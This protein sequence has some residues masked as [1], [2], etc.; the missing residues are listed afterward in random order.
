LIRGALPLRSLP[1]RSRYGEGGYLL[2]R[3]GAYH[4]V[5]T[6]SRSVE[7]PVLCTVSNC[8]ALQH[9]VFQKLPTITL[10]FCILLPAAALS[11]NYNNLTELPAGV[12]GLLPENPDILASVAEDLNGDTLMEKTGNA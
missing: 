3:T 5:T 8:T 12:K 7:N 10:F 6:V 9:H 11:Y 4:D 2:R 1:A